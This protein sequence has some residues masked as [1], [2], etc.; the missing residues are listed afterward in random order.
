MQP[1][2]ENGTHNFAEYFAENVHA[3]GVHPGLAVLVAQV[4]KE[5]LQVLRVI[6]VTEGKITSKFG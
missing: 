4:V 6:N 5:L 2:E 1:T 3:R